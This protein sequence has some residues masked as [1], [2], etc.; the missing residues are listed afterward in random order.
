[1]VGANAA[2]VDLINLNFQG[3]LGKGLYTIGLVS[4]VAYLGFE[5]EPAR[6][7]TTILLLSIGYLERG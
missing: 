5:E 4:R 1:M 3:N 6:R 2:H 7:Y